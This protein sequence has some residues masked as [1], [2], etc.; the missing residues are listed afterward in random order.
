MDAGRLA[1]LGEALKQARL[2]KGES[3][4]DAGR[5]TRIPKKFIDALENGRMDDFPAPVYA[6][7]FLNIYREHLGV[8]SEKPQSEE[9][10]PAASPPEIRAAYPARGHEETARH[11]KPEPHGDPAAYRLILSGSLAALA[12]SAALFWYAS[13]NVGL[14]PRPAAPAAPAASPEPGAAPIAPKVD[15]TVIVHRE[16]WLRVRVDG[17]PAFAGRLARSAMRE[18][19]AR[20]DVVIE[21]GDPRAFD[22]MLN[23]APYS[24]VPN[25]AERYLIRAR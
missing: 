21:T 6:E 20:K 23:G 16:V 18:W 19:K 13:S 2:K 17:K 4:E 25:P 14:S 7:G 12:A 22:L 3:L 11:A 15:L 24:L 8:A 10:L 5:K 1:S 9:A